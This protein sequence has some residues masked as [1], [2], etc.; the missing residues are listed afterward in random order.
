MVKAVTI[1]RCANALDGRTAAVYKGQPCI[2]ARVR[3]M[4]AMVCETATWVGSFD[5]ACSRVW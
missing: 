2:P 5:Q 1:C 4:N 3:F